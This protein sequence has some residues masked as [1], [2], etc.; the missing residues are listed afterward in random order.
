[1]L[2]VRDRRAIQAPADEGDN[3]DRR[4]TGNTARAPGMQPTPDEGDHPSLPI[5]QSAAY[6]SAAWPP[7][8]AAG[9][10][11]HSPGDHSMTAPTWYNEVRFTLPLTANQVN[12]GAVPDSPGCYVFTDDRGALVPGK[13]LY[14]GRALSLRSRLRGY[15][16][17]FMSTAPTRH[18]GR[19]FIFEHRHKYGDD[20]LFVRWAVYGD[21]NTLEASLI[22]HLQPLMNDRWELGGFA[23][24]E[25]LDARYRG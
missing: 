4:R 17:D 8:P 7:K 5:A 21:P 24:D 25:A 23:D 19:A 20:R 15:L 6:V 16:L 9:E 11:E 22:D 14:V 18:K 2:R 10:R 1:M 12:V 13:V 3:R